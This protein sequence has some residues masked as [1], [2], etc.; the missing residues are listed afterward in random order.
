MSWPPDIPVPPFR[1][2]RSPGAVQAAAGRGRLYR[3]R[4]SGADLGSPVDPQEWWQVLPRRRDPAAWTAPGRRSCA[5]LISNTLQVPE[6][7]LGWTAQAARPAA[8]DRWT[9]SHRL[10]R[11]ALA[12]PRT[13]RRPAATLARSPCPPGRPP[14]GTR[15]L[16]AARKRLSARPVRPRSARGPAPG[17]SG[18]ST[19]RCRACISPPSAG[20]RGVEHEAG[21]EHALPVGVTQP[22]P[23]RP[24]SAPAPHA[25]DESGRPSAF[26]SW[27]HCP[28][29]D[30]EAR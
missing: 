3:D 14:P 13:R 23:V 2:C 5:A 1:P 19:Q 7:S 30:Q 10:L 12:G 15:S 9:W 17:R 24:R 29:A 26:L 20:R 21:R 18:P 22:D 8:A 28:Q 4:S 11:P 16:R 25:P 27:G 6:A